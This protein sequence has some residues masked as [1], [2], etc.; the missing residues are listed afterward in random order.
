M[1]SLSVMRVSLMTIAITVW[2]LLVP[3]V[4]LE[5]ADYSN[6]WYAVKCSFNGVCD[7]DDSE[8][9]KKDRY[10]ET[11]W[12]YIEQ[13]DSDFFDAS[14]FTI[15]MNGDWQKTEFSLLT[16]LGTARDA[17]LELESPIT[18]TDAV[19]GNETT[20]HYLFIRLI[21]KEKHNAIASA[22]LSTVEGMALIELIDSAS[23]CGSMQFSGKLTKESKVPDVI[24]AFMP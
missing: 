22:K 19:T 16:Q 4:A 5:Y 23:C 1:R 15:D 6:T 3:A 10:K 13:S 9:I 2:V 20:I 17:V 7:F 11:S 14:L 12:I 18:M 21:G 24:K 8:G